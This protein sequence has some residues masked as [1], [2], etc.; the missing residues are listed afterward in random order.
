MK[1][2]YKKPILEIENFILRECIASSCDMSKT[3]EETGC[4]SVLDIIQAGL[5]MNLSEEAIV[6]EL[7][8]NDYPVCYHTTAGASVFNS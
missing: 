1:R 6:E 5:A 3:F 2:K 7:L 8:A 4:V